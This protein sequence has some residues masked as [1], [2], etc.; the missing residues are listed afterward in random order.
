MR[1]VQVTKLEG[2]E[3][4][5]IVEIAEPTPEPGEVVIEVHA[6]GFAFPDVLQTRG[7]YQYQ[8]D[9]P[10]TLGSEMA[11]VVRTAPADSGL[12]A[13]D[14][15][16]ALG[17][18]RGMAE[19]ACIPSSQ[20]F[21]LPDSVPMEQAA[22]LLF[23]D[24]TVHFVL[25]KRAGM[26]RGETVLVHGAAGGIGVSALRLAPALGAGRVLAVVSDEAKAAV[27]REAGADDVVLVDGWLNRVRELTGSGVDVVVDPV[28]GDRFTDSLRSL[29]PGGRLIVVGFTA[30]EI[31]TV[32][33]NRLL[34]NNIDV[35]G[36]G[37]G[38]WWMTHPG[39][40]HEQWAELE[41]LYANGAIKPLPLT[42]LPFDQALDGLLAIDRRQVTGKIVLKVR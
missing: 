37:W 22:G 38:A 33:V 30:G 12:A 29:R 7:M 16:V 31:P 14:R 34:L 36:A 41:P 20:V 13:G 1:A 32:K 9:L 21:R 6:A 3:S 5:E 39:Y 15:V 11:G 42:V 2:P 24:L 27:A 26:V 10:F 17:I 25:T 19:V 40:L 28:G 23:N 18:N 35:R 8:P 4:V